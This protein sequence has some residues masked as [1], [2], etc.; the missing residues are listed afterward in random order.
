MRFNQSETSRCLPPT[1]VVRREVMSQV[2]D[3]GVGGTVSLGP[4]WTGQGTTPTPR[5]DRW[6][7][8]TG[9][10]GTPPHF[11]RTRQGVPPALFP[12][13]EI[14]AALLRRTGDAA[15]GT[16]LMVAQEDFLLL[17]RMTGII[18]MA[19]TFSNNTFRFFRGFSEGNA[20]TLRVAAA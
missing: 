6:Y 20:K 11:P 19:R 12:G 13:Q 14:I 15:G 17:H 8:Q 16:P 3:G 5:Q 2:V 9:Q 1:Y 7:P 10:R 18:W 4:P